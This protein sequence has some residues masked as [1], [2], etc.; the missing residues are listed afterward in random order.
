MSAIY[1]YNSCFIQVISLNL[2]RRK[3]SLKHNTIDGILYIGDAF[4]LLNLE[5]FT[6]L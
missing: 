1:L 4:Y 5:L 2:L 3:I 6:N